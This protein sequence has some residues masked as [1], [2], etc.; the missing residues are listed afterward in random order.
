MNP[1]KLRTAIGMTICGAILAL[2]GACR[3]QDPTVEEY[4]TGLTNPRGLTFGPDGNLYVAEAGMGGELVPT[5]EA[6]CPRDINIFSPYTAGFSGRVTRVLKDGTTQTVADGLPSMTEASGASY[7]PTDVA[8]IGKTLYVLIE[9]GGCS[10]GLPDEL[11]LP[12]ILRVNADGSTT[13]IA[14]LGAWHRANPA[15]F[16]KDTNPATTDQEPGGVFHSMTAIGEKL[17]VVET[18]RGFLLRVN[19]ANGVIEK[20]YDM[21]IDM[22]EH[23]P[24]VMTRHDKKFYVG[25]F[26]EDGGPSELAVFDKDFSAY[27]LPFESLHP[28]VGL[29]WSGNQLYGLEIFPH[30]DPWTTDNANLVSFDPRT[31]KRT[32]VLV[33]FASLPTG[34]VSG[35]DGALYTSNWALSFEPGDGVILRIQ[36]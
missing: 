25:T 12:A 36:R 24:V 29:A 7:G 13:H 31:G 6:D 32:E 9:M 22:A 27:T 18:N 11:N 30:D 3:F 4:A 14:D 21:S 19:P 8:F 35:P 17:Y 20:L 23:N 2:A 15:T 28:L 1:A 10:H 33:D 5:N 34:L 26:G 16:I